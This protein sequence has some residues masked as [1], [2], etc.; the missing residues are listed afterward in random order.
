MIA[1][2]KSNETTLSDGMQRTFSILKKSADK[3]S[4]NS[5]QSQYRFSTLLSNLS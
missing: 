1:G 2:H 5:A 3:V 4:V